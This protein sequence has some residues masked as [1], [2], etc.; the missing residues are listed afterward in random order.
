M[1]KPTEDAIMT[2]SNWTNLCALLRANPLQPSVTP[3]VPE[4]L[5]YEFLPYI[6]PAYIA[7]CTAAFGGSNANPRQFE[8]PE[9]AATPALY[10]YYSQGMQVVL[11]QRLANMQVPQTKGAQT[12]VVGEPQGT[13]SKEPDIFD[14][15]NRDHSLTSG[16]LLVKV[17][18]NNL[19]GVVPQG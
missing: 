3:T 1:D 16:L 7:G 18:I 15:S 10:A 11:Q 8:I 12:V 19:E 5:L 4:A 17:D 6:H 13:K 14:G 2:T 9:P